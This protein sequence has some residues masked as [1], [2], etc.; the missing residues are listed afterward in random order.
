[1]CDALRAGFFSALT[2]QRSRTGW[3]SNTSCRP[4]RSHSSTCFFNPTGPS[5]Q[6]TVGPICLPVRTAGRSPTVPCGRQYRRRSGKIHRPCRQ[7]SF[8]P[9]CDRQDPGG[10][11]SF[12]RRRRLAP[13]GPQ[14]DQ[15]DAAELSRL[16]D[17]GGEP[18]VQSHFVGGA[19]QP[20]TERDLTDGFPSGFGRHGR[21]LALP[22]WPTTDR[23]A[24]ER[25]FAEGD[26]LDGAGPARHWAPATRR[27][28][29]QHY[30]R[31]L[32]WLASTGSLDERAA[33]W[34]RVEPKTIEAYAR[35]LIC[36]VAPCTAASTLIGLKV[37]MK[38]MRP[39]LS[40]R[41]LMDLSN[42][43]NSWAKPSV[44]RRSA[45]QPS[46][47]IFAAAR[48]ELDRLRTTPL[49]RRIERVAYRAIR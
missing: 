8:V 27:T 34:D 30:A 36:R 28:N 5:C 29:R 1:M 16:R 35:T 48:T 46:D 44:D 47:Q 22:A 13:S 2:G 21:L 10:G 24:W 33:P 31:W 39:D 42:R 6:V 12:A 20:H 3:R 9:A 45:M 38:A 11:R 37:I 15:H 41:W 25:L 23:T 32:G 7:S 26:V 19:R 14:V 43:F 49:T 4:R 17:T 18:A 40:W